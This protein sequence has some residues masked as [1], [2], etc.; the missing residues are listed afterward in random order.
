MIQFKQPNAQT[1]VTYSQEQIQA[2]ES[3]RVQ[4][5]DA[6][7]EDWGTPWNPNRT[8]SRNTQTTLEVKAVLP[9]YNLK[10]YIRYLKS[11]KKFQI[12]LNHNYSRSKSKT[13]EENKE[14]EIRA[15]G[16]LESV[17]NDLLVDRKWEN[18][19]VSVFFV[20]ESIKPLIEEF[21]E[22]LLLME[23]YP[24]LLENEEEE[25]SQGVHFRGTQF[26]ELFEPNITGS[27][28]FQAMFCDIIGEDPRLVISER[29]THGKRRI[30]NVVYD[31]RGGNI[32]ALV[33][34]QD[35]I[36]HGKFLDDEHFDKVLG[37][38]LYGNDKFNTVTKLVFIA[39][40]FTNEQKES[41]K[42]FCQRNPQNVYLIR[43]VIDEDGW[44]SLVQENF[45]ESTAESPRYFINDKE[46][47]LIEVTDIVS[48]LEALETQHANLKNRLISCLSEQKQ[49]GLISRLF[50]S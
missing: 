49:P 47:N 44:V 31:C 34:T 21:K 19:K 18:Q 17:Y 8:N 4:I 9:G 12:G 10:L 45:F 42:R 11:G 6:L 15:K 39:G 27:G 23:T 40:G 2:L 24:P 25:V 35:G 43:S 33:E 26:D 36:Q 41:A 32:V 7:G 16:L 50:K 38:Y 30:D 14:I 5:G 1:T 48:R 28:M 3:L 13:E 22:I 37:S 46:E 29:R 20:S